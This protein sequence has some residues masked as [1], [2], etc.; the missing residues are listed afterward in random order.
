MRHSA[1]VARPSQDDVIDQNAAGLRCKGYLVPGPVGSS[2]L[3]IDLSGIAAVIE[4]IAIRTILD[5]TRLTLKVNTDIV[6][7]NVAG[8]FFLVSQDNPSPFIPLR[9]Y[10]TM[11]DSIELNIQNSALAADP[12]DLLVYYRE[13]VPTR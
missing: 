6:V 5:T 13:A 4:G 10:L 7:D 12:F 9:R 2:I 1:R 8:G 3:R 11:Q